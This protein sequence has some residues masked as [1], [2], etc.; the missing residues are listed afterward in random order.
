VEAGARL[1]V[2]EVAA[3]ADPTRVLGMFDAEDLATSPC[4]VTR[5]SA[6]QPRRRRRRRT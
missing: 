3:V 5:Y 6:G 1:L 4:P 2:N